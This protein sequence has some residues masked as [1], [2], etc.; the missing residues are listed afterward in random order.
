M[1]LKGDYIHDILCKS[2]GYIKIREVGRR[3]ISGIWYGHFDSFYTYL[4]PCDAEF[5][6]V[7]HVS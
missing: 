3:T 2:A 7:E 6:E 1:F 4:D 5:I